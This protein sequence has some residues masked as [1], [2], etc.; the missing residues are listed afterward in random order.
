MTRIKK[1]DKVVV[2]SGKD[3][4]RQGKV[5]KLFPERS[6][7]LVERIN[8]V[9]KHQKAR[10][11]GDQGG[12]IEKEAPIRLCKLMVVCPRCSKPARTGIQVAEDGRKTRFCKKCKDSVDK[13]SR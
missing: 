5:L 12:I 4:G 3:K 1:D 13:E 7:A 9:K 8:M 11:A 6:A 2:L 10:K